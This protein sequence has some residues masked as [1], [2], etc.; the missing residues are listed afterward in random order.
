MEIQLFNMEYWFVGL[1]QK[2]SMYAKWFNWIMS[3]FISY[4]EQDLVRKKWIH[5]FSDQN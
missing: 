5:W 1:Q 4:S 2:T 3:E